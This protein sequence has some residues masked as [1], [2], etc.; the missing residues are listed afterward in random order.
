[1]VDP[2][3]SLHCTSYEAMRI[4]ELMSIPLF[5][6]LSAVD[7]RG[8]GG[9]RIERIDP[10][11]GQVMMKRECGRA[12]SGKLAVSSKFIV[13]VSFFVIRTDVSH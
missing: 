2:I 7:D 1:M 11:S 12:R 4:V 3:V 13:V 10:V 9:V 5:R 8:I 6:V